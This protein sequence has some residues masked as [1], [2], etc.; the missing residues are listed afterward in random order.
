[1]SREGGF[2]PKDTGW[3]LPSP[4]CSWLWKSEV[5]Q[6]PGGSDGGV[7]GRAKSSS[8]VK[9]L[10]VPLQRSGSGSETLTM[11]PCSRFS[12]GFLQ[13]GQLLWTSAMK[14]VAMLK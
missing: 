14:L 8:D 2:C 11:L 10:S 7:L 13:F 9:L 5:E 1:M 12:E 4:L 3:D 6:P